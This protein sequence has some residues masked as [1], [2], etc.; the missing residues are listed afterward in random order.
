MTFYDQGDVWARRYVAAT[1]TWSD[2]QL[3]SNRGV[4][5]DIA[6]DNDGNAIIAWYDPS[7]NRPVYARKFKNSLS[8]LD[9]WRVEEVVAP[10]GGANMAATIGGVDMTSDGGH[11]SVCWLV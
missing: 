3:I 4:N 1:E 5:T 10:G 9:G 6:V 7:V 8:W 11:A 2:L